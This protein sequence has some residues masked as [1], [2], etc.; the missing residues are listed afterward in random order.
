MTQPLRRPA[1]NEAIRSY[2]KTYIVE[3]NL[4][5]GDPLPPEGQLAQELGVGRSSVREAIKALESLGIVEVR[6]GHGLYVREYNF[7][8]ILETLSYGIR[9]DTATLAELAEIRIWLEAA[10]IE[11]AVARISPAAVK[12]L[13]EVMERWAARVTAGRSCADLD[14]EFHRI[15]YGALNN[16]TLLKLIEVFWIT[17]ENLNVEAFQYDPVLNLEEHQAILVAVKAGD[18]RAAR[19]R[20]LENFGHLQ[21]RLAGALVTDA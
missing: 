15:L 19:R 21:E 3:N 12:Q 4:S 10:V 20:L 1:L 7:D 5:A 13:E 8:P 11:E 16:N 17:F 14:E 18:G 9:F 6:H 2:V